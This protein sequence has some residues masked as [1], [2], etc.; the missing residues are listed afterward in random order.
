M[1]TNI[2]SNTSTRGITLV[3]LLVVI[4]I[5][6]IFLS[7]AV[8]Q[9][10]SFLVSMRLTSQVNEL[11]ADIRYARSEAGARGRRVVICPTNDG[12]TSCSTVEADWEKGRVIFVDANLDGD[13]QSTETNLKLVGSLSNGSSVTLSGF[14]TVALGFN[15]YGGLLQGNAL[16]GSGAIQICSASSTNGRQVRVDATGRPAASRINC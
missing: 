4:T 10:S 2:F 11:V 9:F 14:N 8:P 16:G 6:G 5:I 12:G 3:E 1:Q 13:I 7:V 15:P